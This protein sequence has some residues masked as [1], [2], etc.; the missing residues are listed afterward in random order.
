MM[1]LQDYMAKVGVKKKKTVDEWIDKDLIPGAERDAITGEYRFLDSSRWP[2]RSA[3]LKAGAN[4]DK[5]RAH[6]VR[7][8]LERKYISAKMCFASNG[9]FTA[10][11]EDLVK[12]E[13]ILVRYEDGIMYLDST[14]KSNAFKKSSMLEL[15]KFVLECLTALAEGAATG[16]AK[17]YL[18][19]ISGT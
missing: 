16:T 9:E 15:R 5:V 7:A 10:M 18:E 19:Q 8:A 1:N 2:Y 17:A 3:G 6:I 4:A 14:T 11:I 13:L 12:A